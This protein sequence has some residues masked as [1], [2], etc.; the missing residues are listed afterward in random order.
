M[1]SI[2]RSKVWWNEG[3]ETEGECHREKMST[4]EKA[5]HWERI[6]KPKGILC[7]RP[8]RENEKEVANSKY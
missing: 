1:Q 4:K 6:T 2:L 8:E 7:K 3:G 5:W